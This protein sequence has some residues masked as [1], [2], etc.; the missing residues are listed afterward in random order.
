MI[1]V[2]ISPRAADLPFAQWL[3]EI[4]RRLVAVTA[5]GIASG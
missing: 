3:P 4:A 2:L 1:L 5:P